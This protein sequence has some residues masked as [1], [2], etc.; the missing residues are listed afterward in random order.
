MSG[1]PII[2]EGWGL[3][4]ER[5]APIIDSPARMVV[6]VATEEFRLRQLRASAD[7]DLAARG[8]K[9]SLGGQLYDPRRPR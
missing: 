3:R 6:I 1:R 9:L 4:P 5:A 8:I 7:G 2:A